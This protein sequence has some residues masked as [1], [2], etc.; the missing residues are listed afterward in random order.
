MDLL[1]SKNYY[2]ASFAISKSIYYTVVPE[3]VQLAACT[4]SPKHCAGGTVGQTP[5]AGTYC[6][7][8]QNP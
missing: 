1:K 6:C 2:I 7:G 8:M 4:G 5:A 3:L